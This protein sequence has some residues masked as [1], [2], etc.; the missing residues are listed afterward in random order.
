MEVD[1]AAAKRRAARV[2]LCV[3]G[4]LL[5]QA[6]LLSHAAPRAYGQEPVTARADT[7][8]VRFVDSDLRAVVLALGAYL[9][10]PVVISG[11][12]ESR[13]T[14]NT[15]RPVRAE[16]IGPLLRGLLASQRLDLV[17]DSAAHL[18]RIAPKA[19]DTEPHATAGGG[20]RNQVT[21]ESDASSLNLYMLRLRHARAAD[22]AATVS[23]VYGRAVAVGER[24]DARTPRAPRGVE[25]A[26]S[27]AARAQGTGR[28]AV[29]GDAA[30]AGDVTIVPD[31]STN[32]LMIRATTRD[33]ALIVAAVEQLD[34]RPLQ[35]LVE[36]LIA[37]V[38]RDRGLTFG[39]GASVPPQPIGS[40]GDATISAQSEGVGLGDFVVSLMNL[41]GADLDAT[42]RAAA[43]RGDATIRSRPVLLAANNEPAEILVGSQR[44]YIEVSRSL[45]TDAPQR[46]QVVQYRD[47]GTRLAVT[48]TISVDGFVMLEVVQEVN[49]VTAETAFDAP[50]I[51]T[52]T[53]RTR[54]LV[55]DGQTAVL[56]GLSDYQREASQGGIPILSSIPLL[57]GLFGRA[58]RRRI[59]TELFVFLTPRVLRDDA[60]VESTTDSLRSRLPGP[61]TPGRNE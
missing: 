33:H 51:S 36:V 28:E 17:L 32:S 16:A 10:F 6:L 40:R 20:S 22:I 9:D 21:S 39:V 50:V 46:D 11:L 14:L 12:P 42:L 48:P 59:E 60:Q 26:G 27:A 47:V 25:A 19:T 55:R 2:G 54:L 30:F 1:V 58:S 49:A 18:Y 24:G 7:V 35:V 37:E 38:R 45:P 44:P 13:V 53:V 29:V 57:G 15:P 23:A 3:S 43:S 4:G 41:G 8:V 56:G 61:P 52:R 5:V 34:V 31:A